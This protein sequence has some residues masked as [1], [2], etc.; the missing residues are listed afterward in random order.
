MIELA[1]DMV[2]VVVVVVVVLLL[3]LMVMLFG[4][5][6]RA[7]GKELPTSASCIAYKSAGVE[8][9]QSTQ[10]DTITSIT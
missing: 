1:V 5:W 2:V 6:L 7:A 9:K 10:T 3:L 8:V 4:C